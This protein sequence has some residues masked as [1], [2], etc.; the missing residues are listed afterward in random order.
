[1]MAMKLVG[2]LVV[3]KVEM[4]VDL[5]VVLKDALLVEMKE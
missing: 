3:R 2:Q 4:L 1:M 5:M